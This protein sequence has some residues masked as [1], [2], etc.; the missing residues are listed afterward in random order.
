MKTYDHVNDCKLEVFL[1]SNIILMKSSIQKG[2]AEHKCE[3]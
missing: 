2:R 1:N 3:H